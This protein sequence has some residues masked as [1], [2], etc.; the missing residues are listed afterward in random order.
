MG[1]SQGL[2]RVLSFCK[3]GPLRAMNVTGQVEEEQVNAV[4]VGPGISAPTQPLRE[5]FLR[6]ILLLLLLVLLVLL[7]LL[8]LLYYYYYHYHYHY[9]YHHHHHHYYYY[10]CFILLLQLLLLLLLCCCCCHCCCWQVEFRMQA[11]GFGVFWLSGTIKVG[12]IRNGV[13]RNALTHSVQHIIP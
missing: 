1:L 3:W 10:Y 12:T 9:Y 11:L 7:L 2:F 4:G 8:V 6:L 13:T 5:I